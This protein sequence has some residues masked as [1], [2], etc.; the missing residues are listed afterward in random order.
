MK[1]EL[2]FGSTL[3]CIDPWPRPGL[4]FKRGP[5]LNYQYDRFRV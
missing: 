2:G 4:R 1:K 5:R 3:E